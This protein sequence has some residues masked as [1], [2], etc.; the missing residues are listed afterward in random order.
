MDKEA[1][2]T[3]FVRVGWLFSRVAWLDPEPTHAIIGFTTH[4]MARLHGQK[5]PPIAIRHKTELLRL[6]NQ[7]LNDPAQALSDGNIGSVASFTSHEVGSPHLC[8]CVCSYMVAASFW[9]SRRF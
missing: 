1:A 3:D 4:H 9:S 8:L 7:R 5:E 2:S 6:I